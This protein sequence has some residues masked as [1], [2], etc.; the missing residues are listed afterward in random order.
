[1]PSILKIFFQALFAKNKSAED[2]I[3]V[4]LHFSRTCCSPLVS[5]HRKS[6]CWE[7]TCMSWKTT[8]CF[9]LF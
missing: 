3:K 2:K 6:A 8:M 9:K 5:Q 4:I 1:M 7:N